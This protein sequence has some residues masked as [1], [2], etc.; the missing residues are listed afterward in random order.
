MPEKV[1][2]HLV[3]DFDSG[4][5]ECKFLKVLCEGPYEPDSCYSQQK[6]GQEIDFSVVDDFVHNVLDEPGFY[7]VHYNTDHKTGYGKKVLVPVLE[8][9]FS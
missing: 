4:N 5:V 6:T 7:V 3:S 8:N 2:A 9:V 1:E